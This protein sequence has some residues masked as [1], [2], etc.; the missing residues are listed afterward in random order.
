M[1]PLWP[2]L[3]ISGSAEGASASSSEEGKNLL[4]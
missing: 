3:K 4:N 1:E 2:M